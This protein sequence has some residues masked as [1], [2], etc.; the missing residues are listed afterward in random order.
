MCDPCLI[1]KV[2][3]NYCVI[4]IEHGLRSTVDTFR[5]Q[6]VVKPLYEVHIHVL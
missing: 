3:Y 4:Q 6:E 5:L 2:Y 1:W